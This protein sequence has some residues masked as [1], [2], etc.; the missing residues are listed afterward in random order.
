[1][2]SWP[3]GL[4]QMPGVTSDDSFS[5]RL[6][7]AFDSGSYSDLTV[8]C[9]QRKWK[10]H[11]MQ[12]VQHSPVFEAMVKGLSKGE[13]TLELK[14]D[15]PDAVNHMLRYMYHFCY[16]FSRERTTIV[17]NMRVHKVANKYQIPGLAKEAWFRY[18]ISMVVMPLAE[19]IT[20]VKE[21]YGA[22]G[23]DEF[24]KSFL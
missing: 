9:K 14:D 1:M 2:S 7:N 6:R 3:P 19:F 23:Y 24:R 5:I 20:G 4:D 16:N 13:A 11:R 18:G 8:I 22:D 10:V 17:E 21:A 15:D 12:L